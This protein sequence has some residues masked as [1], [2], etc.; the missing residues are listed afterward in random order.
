MTITSAELAT[1]AV[2]LMAFYAAVWF[3]LLRKEGK[4]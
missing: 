1:L 3:F 2:M 4:R